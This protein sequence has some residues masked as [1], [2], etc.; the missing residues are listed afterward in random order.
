[1]HK[2][3]L[4]I[5]LFL[6][7][8]SCGYESIY[9]DSGNSNFNITESEFVGDGEINKVIRERLSKKKEESIANK[10]YSIKIISQTTKEV[11]S[12][13]A[14]GKPDLFKMVVE[15]KIIVNSK[16]IEKNY[17]KVFLGNSTYRN[18]TNKFS[19][20]EYEKIIKNNIANRIVNSIKNYLNF[21]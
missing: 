5:F 1:M 18:S 17:E 7:T 13:D 3:I 16:D 9:L 11:R 8:T 12:K 14:K 10:D 2:K 4:L 21:L 19:L 15:V 6:V 20:A